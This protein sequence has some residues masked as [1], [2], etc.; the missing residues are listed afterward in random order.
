MAKPTT[1]SISASWD[2]YNN[3]LRLGQLFNLTC[4]SALGTDY[5]SLAKNKTH[6]LVFTFHYDPHPTNIRAQ[7]VLAAGVVKLATEVLTTAQRLQVSQMR[8]SEESSRTALSLVVCNV[9]VK[10]GLK[11]GG[12]GLS[13][14]LPVP[15]MLSV[16]MGWDS[17]VIDR[18]WLQHLK[19]ELASPEAHPDYLLK[20]LMLV[21][22]SPNSTPVEQRRAEMATRFRQ[23]QAMIKLWV[24]RKYD[25]ATV[26]ESERLGYGTPSKKR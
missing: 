10:P 12:D 6:L 26:A 25:A 3:E 15:Q 20:T 4:Y 22:S 1:A 9:I 19:D 23:P 8:K 13:S 18:E 17:H 11:D 14:L 24:D 21:N 5:P 2:R 7:F 16:P